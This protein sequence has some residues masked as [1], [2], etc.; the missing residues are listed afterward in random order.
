MPCE[1]RHVMTRSRCW[2]CRSV[3]TT[4]VCPNCKAISSVEGWRRRAKELEDECERHE[5]KL[6]K[7]GGRYDQ[8]GMG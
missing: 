7:G 4:K 6:K 8:G 5:R 1:R 3:I 2:N